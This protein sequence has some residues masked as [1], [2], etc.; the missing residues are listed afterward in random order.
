[1]NDFRKAS[2]TPIFVNEEARS[3][4]H[5]RQPLWAV[6]AA[7]LVGWRMQEPQEQSGTEK[8]DGRYC[9]LH[10]D[11][12]AGQEPGIH[13]A[14]SK[15]LISL[16]AQQPPNQGPARWG[17]P[18]RSWKSSSAQLLGPLREAISRLQLGCP[19]PLFVPS[20]RK[21]LNLII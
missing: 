10:S 18:S 14:G 16:S 7:F 17:S 15:A 9:P 12:C 11:P 6:G 21:N 13:T 1:M 19:W 2:F 4:W 5:V 3:E 20:G 8:G